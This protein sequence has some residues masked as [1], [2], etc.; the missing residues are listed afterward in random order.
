MP[1]AAGGAGQGGASA[2][3]LH[4]PAE[5]PSQDRPTLATSAQGGQGQAPWP[6]PRETAA[7]QAGAGLGP[8]RGLQDHRSPAAPAR[9]PQA[10]ARGRVHQDAPLRGQFRGVEADRKTALDPWVESGSERASCTAGQGAKRHHGDGKTSP[11]PASCRTRCPVRSGGGGRPTAAGSQAGGRSCA[12]PGRRAARR[13][14][15]RDIHAG[16][17]VLQCGRRPWRIAR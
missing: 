6:P 5:A 8:D 9:R 12:R 3:T 16:K 2:L 1:R 10:V 11:A 17:G 13:H 15:A 4:G 7:R 14:F